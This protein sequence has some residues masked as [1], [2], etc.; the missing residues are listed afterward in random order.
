MCE[1]WCNE[2]AQ[3]TQH[4]QHG[5]GG[6]RGAVIVRHHALILSSVG[7]SHVD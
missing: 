1:V 5:F 3:L 2:N 7:M 4:V 6:V